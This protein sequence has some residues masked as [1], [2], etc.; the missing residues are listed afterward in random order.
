MITGSVDPSGKFINQFGTKNLLY[1]QQQKNQK[2]QKKKKKCFG[3]QLVF[4]TLKLIL[5]SDNV[6]FARP[7]CLIL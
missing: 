7:A 5:F 1:F 4:I 3:E 6:L 2:Y